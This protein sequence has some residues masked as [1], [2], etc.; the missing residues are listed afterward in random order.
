MGGGSRSYWRC[1][2][3]LVFCLVSFFSFCAK[4]KSVVWFCWFC[5]S[6][7]VLFIEIFV[8][9]PEILNNFQPN[10]PFV[11]RAEDGEEDRS[12]SANSSKKI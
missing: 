8:C 4:L 6:F 9:F 11:T 10:P 2:N 1:V 7:V 12:R 3:Y 5:F